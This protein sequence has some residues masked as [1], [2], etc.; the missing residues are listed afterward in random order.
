MGEGGVDGVRRDVLAGDILVCGYEAPAWGVV[1]SSFS[2]RRGEETGG[3]L[4]LLTEVPV[5]DG[6]GDDVLE[7]LKLPRDERPVRP[8]AGVRDVEVV[9]ALLGRELG[10]GLARDEVAERADLALELARLV[11][12]LDPLGDAGL[13][14]VSAAVAERWSHVVP[15]PMPRGSGGVGELG[16]P[17]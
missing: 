8:G 7:A 13:I 4:T 1:S 5:D 6:E 16:L 17:K 10:A 15:A 14:A 3:K 11:V 2:L 9:A 12:R